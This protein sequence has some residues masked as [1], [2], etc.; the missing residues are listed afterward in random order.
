MRYLD[1]MMPWTDPT[2]RSVCRGIAMEQVIRDALEAAKSAAKSYSR[3]PSLAEAEDV[4]AAWRRILALHEIS[5][6]RRRA[7]PQ[8]PARDARDQQRFAW[9][10]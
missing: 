2:E 3:R 1:G 4:D 7:G 5:R 6:W 9:A 10:E 8:R